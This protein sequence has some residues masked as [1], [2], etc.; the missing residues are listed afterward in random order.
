MSVCEKEKNY[1][2][3]FI[4]CRSCGHR[5]I[6]KRGVL[7]EGLRRLCSRCLGLFGKRRLV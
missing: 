4:F 6:L 5:I 2:I 1:Y 7:L 3:N